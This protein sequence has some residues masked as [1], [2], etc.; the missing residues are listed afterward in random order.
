MQMTGSL[1][2]LPLNGRFVLHRLFI[3][4][5]CNLDVLIFHR[6]DREW[7][8]RVQVENDANTCSGPY[9]DH[10]R[11]LCCWLRP[12]NVHGLSAGRLGGNSGY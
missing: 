6:S 8:P 4:F 12:G 9:C 7:H 3:Y 1:T 5:R 2:L 11:R 10:K